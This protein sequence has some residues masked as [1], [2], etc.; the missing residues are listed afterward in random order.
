MA[1]PEM[2]SSMITSS[3]FYRQYDNKVISPS[4]VYHEPTHT[5]TH[6]L[7]LLGFMSP[8]IMLTGKEEKNV[9]RKS[10]DWF[11]NRTL[12]WHSQKGPQN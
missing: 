2:C 12:N 3:S 7:N 8:Q 10:T 4:G 9:Y 11:T 6:S 1:I 5:L